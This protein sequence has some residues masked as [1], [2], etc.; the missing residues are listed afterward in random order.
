MTFVYILQSQCGRH[1]Y[2]GLTSD[3]GARLT[4]HNEG[5]VRHTSKFRPWVLRSYIA[6]SDRSRAAAFESYLKS[7]S[8]RA[9]ATKRL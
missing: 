9:F 8:G 6:F 3:I 5:R 4:A 7:G 2:V 1:F